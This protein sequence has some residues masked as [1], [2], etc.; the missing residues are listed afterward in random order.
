MAE[1]RNTISLTDRVSS[2]MLGIQRRAEALE[3]AFASLDSVSVS[4][5]V[6]G[7]DA[8]YSTVGAVQD[9]V[10]DLSASVDGIT[11]GATDFDDALT[12]AL[13]TAQQ[14]ASVLSGIA[15]TPPPVTPTTTPASA[16][17]GVTGGL[18]TGSGLFVTNLNQGLQILDR[19][20]AKVDDIMASFDSS[21]SLMSRL[22]LFGPEGTNG[23]DAYA[24]IY[25]LAQETRS[26]IAQTANIV[27]RTL[28]SGLFV[29]E[30]ALNNSLTLA[31]LLNKS[32]A[33]TG[34]TARQAASATEQILQ[35]LGAGQ[36]YWQ[37]LRIILQQAPG[38]A[39]DLVAGLNKALDWDIGLGDLK[40]LA[41][42]GE[43]TA[44]RIVKA[45][46]AIGDE[47]EERF[48]TIPMLWS[49]NQAR[50]E[51][52]FTAFIGKLAEVDGPLDRLNERFTRFVDTLVET[53][54]GIVLMEN[55][56]SAANLVAEIIGT[57]AEAIANAL[58]YIGEN[59]ALLYSILVVVISYVIAGL[60]QIVIRMVLANIVLFL[61]IAAVYVL[62]QVFMA[63]GF[64]AQ[65]AFALIAFVVGAVVAVIWDAVVL[66]VAAIAAI[67]AFIYDVLVAI[68]GAIILVVAG[69]IQLIVYLVTTIINILLAIPKF[70]VSLA[71][72]IY[73][74][75]L[76]AVTGVVTLFALLA[77]S[78][79]AVIWGLAKAIDFVFGTNLADGV[80]GWIDNV[81]NLKNDINAGLFDDINGVFDYN[82]DMWSNPDNWL[83]YDDATFIDD[84]ATDV[85][86]VLGDL[87]IGPDEAFNL[88]ADNGLVNPMDWGLAAAQWGYDLTD[89]GSIDFGALFGDNFNMSDFLNNLS[90]T[91][92]SIGGGD[93]DSVG[94]IKSDVNIADENL[95]LLRDVAARDFLLNLSQIT[96]QVSV[97]FTGDINETAD[98]NVIAE[99]LAD[100]LEEAA[101]SSLVFR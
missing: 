19:I 72:V 27:S 10:Q 32:L 37:D 77:E 96:P 99:A 33:S 64:T 39:A 79:L 68:A 70:I 56:G 11:D 81:E 30:N 54:R 80:Q 53:E 18:V 36:L 29:G 9:Q 92:L 46:F 31:G 93:L 60:T 90:D 59:A 98:V 28:V 82:L 89:T 45:F 21:R 100:L 3:R 42:E 14:L 88:I 69:I 52:F 44:D 86:G 16:S 73:G 22:E 6:D 4:G 48:Q 49:Q 57:G 35:G 13:N 26:T 61:I 8:V 63:M 41:S 67:V 58:L 12:N 71:S 5:L 55:L 38:L 17:G 91:D 78:V 1:I 15:G 24:Q 34:A 83:G 84:F 51:N 2:V 40:T 20:K 85:F 43:L 74:A 94:K 75:F 97:Q 25:S 101:A 23:V 76:F 95:E 65:E 62:M 66:I 7:F 50:M 87:M 47:I